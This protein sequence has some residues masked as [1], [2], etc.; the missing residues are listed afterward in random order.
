[1]NSSSIVIGLVIVALILRRQLRTRPVRDRATFIW[2]GVLTVLGILAV[3]FGVKSVTDHHSLS[4]VTYSAL[5]ASC[6]VAAA[7]GAVRART[8]QVWRGPEGEPLRKG[9][10]VTA[11]A[12]LASIAANLGMETWIDSTTGVGVLGF[13]TV[14]LYLAVGLGAQ[15][16]LVRRRAAAVT[17]PA[18]V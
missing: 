4:T 15:A 14:Y 9:T 5:A 13:S 11:V 18:A 7:F 17:V 6:A 16:L 10:A 8:V 12:W 2:I 1:M 3:T